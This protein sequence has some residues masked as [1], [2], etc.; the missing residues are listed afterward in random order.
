MSRKPWNHP[1]SCRGSA[2]VEISGFELAVSGL[3]NP[4]AQGG[5][6]MRHSVG[7]AL[8]VLLLLGV[9]ASAVAQSS[10]SGTISGIVTDAGGSVLPGV[11]VTALSDALV[12]GRQ[13]AI[14]DRSGVYRFPSLPPGNYVLQAELA[15]FKPVRR[16]NVRVSLGQRLDVD[17]TLPQ[18]TATEAI[19]VVAEAPL[20]SVASNAVSTY[21]GKDFLGNQ[22]LARNYYNII[23]A[24]PGVNIDYTASSGSAML[25]YGSYSERQNAFTMDGVNVADAAAGQH[26]ILPSIEWMEEIQVAGLGANAEYGGY[27]GGIINGVTK[28]GGN[29]F[30]GVA[31]YYY[32]PNSWVSN[33]DPTQEQPYTKFTDASV[34][35]G[36]S[37]IKDRLWYFVSGER[38]H[39]ITTPVGAVADSDREIP[40]YLGKLTFQ[41]DEANRLWLMGEY[42]HV[43]NERRGIDRYTL[44]EATS[45]QDGPGA[46][47]SASWESIV[48]SNNFLNIRLTGYDGRDDYLPYHGLDTPGRIDEDTGIEWVNQDIHEF[49]HRHIETL[50]ASWSLF[51]DALLGAKDSH[52]F[53]F[54]VS[55]EKG[56]SSD[57]WLRNGG[58]TYYDWSGDCDSVEEYFADPSCGPYYVERG[59]GEY[60]E[61]P[62]F[63]GLHL[64]AQDSLR[65][66]RL[67]INAGVRYGSYKGG[68]QAGHG[69]STVYDVNFVDPRIGVV[70]D[71]FGNAHSALKAHWGRY[72]QKIF[73]Y[74]WDREA[75]G[76]AVVP[77]QDCYW[78]YDTNA[79]TDCDPLTTV[80]ARMGKV[81][82]P[83]VD[84]TLLTFEQQVGHEM[85]LGVDLIDRRFR[86]FMAMVN[87]NPDYEL[88]TATGNPYGGGDIP[89]YDLLSAQDWVLTSDN[90]G[91]RNFRSA[92]LRFDKRYADGWSLMSS[93]V[94]S[95]LKGNV[96][97]DD[98]Y[99]GEFEDINGLFN[100]DGRMDLSFSKWEFKLTG[101]VDLPLGFVASGQYSY[102]SGWYWTPYLRVRG[103]DYNAYTGRYI[104][105]TPRGSQKFPDRSL[106][107]LRLAWATSLSGSVK[108][109]ASLECFNCQNK[110][111][112]LNVSQRWGDY[113]LGNSNPWRPNSSF[114]EA[115]SIERPREV[116][117]GL[118][119]EF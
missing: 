37:V 66:D 76:D 5:G 96:S 8:L 27:T 98:G 16:E 23:K 80:A 68:W 103:L 21:F 119:L 20:V 109:T 49:N 28:S 17:I 100:A 89:I 83:Y 39:Q 86:S 61:W 57:Q 115:T 31:E 54:G 99:A 70:W 33:N 60:H 6:V 53:K 7:G 56:S 55:Y 13:V 117:A 74:L 118:R 35:L 10:T 19:T 72:H 48:N 67:T 112:V 51:K 34:S 77:D 85:A 11:T 104:N 73:T 52:S 45:K 30:A 97:S 36:G 43:V 106:I 87:E 38:W 42:D 46:S 9:A 59:W 12:T 105:L 92:V 22:P 24:A 18:L 81:N 64:Y 111:T 41:A 95:D 29:A 50:D 108:L 1:A 114:G 79:Y 101:S 69:T 75:S 90:P 91:Y 82:H 63:S 47:L 116:R 14:T 58:F 65:L 107:D 44:P 88:Y 110:D 25:A 84:E 94:W 40:R 93:L 71:L 32:E 2:A 26:W 3:P 62:K 4:A 102:F 78:D 15:G 113:R